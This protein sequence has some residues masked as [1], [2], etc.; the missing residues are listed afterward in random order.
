MYKVGL[1]FKDVVFNWVPIVWDSN[2]GLHNRWKVQTIHCAMAV[3]YFII[4]IL[5]QRLVN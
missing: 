2:L 1:L 3:P 4:L 5:C